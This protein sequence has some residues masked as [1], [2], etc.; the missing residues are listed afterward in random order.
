MVKQHFE[1]PLP[2]F[3]NTSAVIDTQKQKPA[4]FFGN[5]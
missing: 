4:F 2:Q 3:K 1:I 5:I